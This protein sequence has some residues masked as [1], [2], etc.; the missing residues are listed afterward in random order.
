M[1]AKYCYHCGEIA[2]EG[3]Y[4]KKC[5]TDT[6]PPN[7]VYFTEEDCGDCDTPLPRWANFCPKCGRKFGFIEPIDPQ[8]VAKRN[9]G[10]VAGA[11]FF[12]IAAIVAALVLSM[13]E[14]A[15]PVQY[16]LV[17]AAAFM[18]IIWV[19][20]AIRWE[21]AKYKDGSV[22]RH[23]SEDRVRGER[24]INVTTISGRGKRVDIHYTLYSTEVRFDD[25]T[26]ET[27]NIECAAN[28]I[29]MNIG[30]RIRYYLST[31]TYRKL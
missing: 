22:L 7:D 31:R 29:Q 12:S 23:F 8:K 27:F 9:K 6:A 20:T 19:V 13:T 15:I 1:M 4:C 25:G 28:H 30:D 16:A 18:L 5:G 17:G 11:V 2:N 3:K 14:D 24:D 26:T 21:R 10:L